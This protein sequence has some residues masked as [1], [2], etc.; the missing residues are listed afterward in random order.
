MVLNLTSFIANLFLYCNKNKWLLGNKKEMYVK[1][2]SL[3][4]RFGPELP[5]TIKRNFKSIYHNVNIYHML[6]HISYV[7]VDR[8]YSI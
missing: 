8:V 2:A 7:S 5:S 6:V 3:V 1:Q 4:T